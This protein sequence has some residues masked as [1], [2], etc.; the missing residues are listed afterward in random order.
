MREKLV[1]RQ[2]E[3]YVN[4]IFGLAAPKY[5]LLN[6]IISFGR[7]RRWR[8]TAAAMAGPLPGGTA[9]DVASGTGDLALELSRIVGGTGRVVAADFC[10]PMLEL[11][12]RKIAGRAGITLVAANAERLPF[13]ANTFDCAAIGFALRNVSSVP[14][15]IA[16][17]VRVIKPGGRV[18]SVEIV[19]PRSRL[20]APLWR[21]YFFWLM[22][23]LAQIFGAQREPYDYLP[24]S[25]AGF[26]SR[27]ELADIF[28][29]CGLKDV[30]VRNLTFGVV[31]IHMGT[32]P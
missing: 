25:V 3:Q 27:E 13:A 7:H 8:R 11:A 30:G 4:R 2:K 28:D 29:D 24:D 19:G 21:S 20:L 12:A 10:K 32:K 15:T 9:L 26:Y 31:C 16:E 17:M 5:D 22:P 6:S 18:I 23:R 1:G 14:A